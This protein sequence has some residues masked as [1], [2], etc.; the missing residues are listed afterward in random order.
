MTGNDPTDQALAMIASIFETPAKARPESD[1]KSE[2]SSADK[3]EAQRRDDDASADASV[4]QPPRDDGETDLEQ[5]AEAD[6]DQAA[7]AFFG[8]DVQSGENARSEDAAPALAAKDGEAL[9]PLAEGSVSTT[10]QIATTEIV[11]I[12]FTTPAEAAAPAAPVALRDDGSE[13]LD[14]LT[15]YG[16]GPLEALRFKWTVRH[17]S[18]GY[19]VDETIGTSSQPIT[20]GPFS[21]AAAIDFIDGRDRRTRRRF[22]RL[23]NEIV[24]GPSERGIEDDDNE[25]L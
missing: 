8:D 4:G 1:G 22:E 24:S 25:T 20:S 9:P 2:D 3:P 16:P 19:Y 23:R 7:G 14:A 11:E 13:D 12:T 17:E 5:A 21:R 10:V 18:D 6:F 15:R